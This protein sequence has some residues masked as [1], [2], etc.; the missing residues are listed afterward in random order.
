MADSSSS[1]RGTRAVLEEEDFSGAAFD[2]LKKERIPDVDVLEV[3]LEG[4]EEGCG[5]SAREKSSMAT[6]EVNGG[7]FSL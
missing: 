1:E 4:A 6:E 5:S 3:V 2:P 7:H